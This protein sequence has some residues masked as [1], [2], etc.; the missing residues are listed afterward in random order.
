MILSLNKPRYQKEVETVKAA[1]VGPCKECNGQGYRAT[2]A[3]DPE[4]LSAGVVSC[5]CAELWNFRLRQMGANLPREF[6]DVEKLTAEF[7]KGCFAEVVEYLQKIESALNHGLGFLMIG[8]N[9]V[10]KTT[11]GAMI[12]CKAIRQGYSALYL[13]SHDLTD[14]VYTSIRDAEFAAEFNEKLDVDFMV[15]DELDKVHIKT[16]STFIQSKI[17][18][19][20]R[21]RA[22]SLKPTTIITNMSQKDLDQAFGA[23]V[24]SILSGRL[25]QLRFLPGDYRKKQGE[26]WN[27][28]LES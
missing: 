26:T 11:A 16:D 15:L 24:M 3:I 4:T 2:G 8:E 5:K 7:N 25:K 27:D 14:A 23:S 22:S 12:I 19:I 6:W 9:G 18:S 21:Q 28:L 1:I 20:L 17:D 10:G 13:T